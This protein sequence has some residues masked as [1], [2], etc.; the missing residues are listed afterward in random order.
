MIKH[1]VILLINAQN[2]GVERFVFEVDLSQFEQQR[3]PRR[4][5]LQDLERE[6]QAFILKLNMSSEEHVP[7]GGN[8]LT[9]QIVVETR[10][11]IDG[12]ENWV[13]CEWPKADEP[14]IVPLKSLS[15]IGIKFQLY[16]EDLSQA[17]LE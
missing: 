13:K 9:W 11:C 12:G 17:Y 6:F 5:S 7:P 10:E 16:R 2:I 8:G 14:T 15:L 1:V 4:Y 3:I